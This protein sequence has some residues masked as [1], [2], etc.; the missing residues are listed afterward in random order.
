MRNF[1]ELQ[2][3]QK[4]HQ[5]VIEVYRITKLFPSNERFGLTS[6]I[7]RSAASVPAN[8]AEG[9]G[10]NGDRNFCRFLSI[11]AGSASETEYHLILVRDLRL[12]NENDYTNIDQQIKEIKNML[13]SFMH[14]LI[15]EA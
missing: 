3:W 2:V 6:Q 10:R 1:K 15:P 4:S 7:R 8:T 9:C 13:N 11:A 14:K 5:M 12:P